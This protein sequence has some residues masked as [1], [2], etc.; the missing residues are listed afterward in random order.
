MTDQLQ[1]ALA[2]PDEETALKLVQ[3]RL[4]AKQDPLSILA[5]CRDGTA[6]VGQPYESGDYF[7]SELIMAG[8]IFKQVVA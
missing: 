2:D 6:L 3:E 8:K 1:Q 7:L 4:A 5:S